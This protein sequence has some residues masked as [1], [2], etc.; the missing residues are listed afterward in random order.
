METFLG[1]TREGLERRL[2]AAEN[3]TAK[4]TAELDSE[5]KRVVSRE[6]AA[7]SENLEKVNVAHRAELREAKEAGHA[8]A[9]ALEARALE[10][11]EA[12]EVA[13]SAAGTAKQELAELVEAAAARKGEVGA[14]KSQLSSAYFHFGRTRSKAG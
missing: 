10:A 11:A 5:R 2:T 9:R 1:G 7:A 4:V 6:R 8:A 3:A 14:Q 12:A 13:A